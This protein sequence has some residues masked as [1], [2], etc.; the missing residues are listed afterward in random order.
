MSFEATAI[1][2]GKAGDIIKVK[3]KNNHIYKVKIDKQ[4][5]GIL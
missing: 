1:Q 4:G 5:N 3:D 2:N